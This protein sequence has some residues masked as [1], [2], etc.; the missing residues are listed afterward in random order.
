MRGDN[1]NRHLNWKLTI[2]TFLLCFIS[3]SFVLAKDI[4]WGIPKSV[5]HEQPW[6][7]QEYDTII[8]QNDAYYIGS[9]DEKMIYLTFDCGYENGNTPLILDV[10]KK[11]EVPALFF[12]TGHFMEQNPDLVKRMVEEG[13]II[14]NHTW[15]HPDL[16]KVSK[17]KFNEELQ[18]V[19]N[20]YKELTG[21]EMVRYLRPP[22]GHF[23][24][25]MLDFAKERGYY[26]ILWSLAYM[27]WDVNHQKGADYAYEQIL[28][29]MH[30]GAIILMH[31][32]SSDNAKCL[33]Q[34]IPELRKQGYEFKSLQ[35]L[36][37]KDS[38]VVI[39]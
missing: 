35:Y 7:G 16:A 27:D 5:N 14:G 25:Q 32:I 29:R 8:R 22:E 33:D 9:P 24:Q 4:G 3:N 18:L 28:E 23:N 19:E 31:S 13:H 20:R 21:K 11:Y 37:T 6:P 39:E 36:M 2:L 26:T 38:P 30:P 17:E 34:L 12:V 15:H 10:L 1:V